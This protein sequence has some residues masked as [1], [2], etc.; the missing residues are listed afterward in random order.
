M[1]NEREIAFAR[2]WEGKEGRQLTVDVVRDA[3][4]AGWSDRPSRVAP[5]P[6]EYSTGAENEHKENSTFVPVQKTGTVL[7]P[8]PGHRAGAE[9]VRLTYTNWRGEIAKRT[10]APKYVWFGSTDWHPHPQWLLKAFDLEKGEDRDFALKDFGEAK[11]AATETANHLRHALKSCIMIMQMAT[12][13][14]G[15]DEF[16]RAYLTEGIHVAENALTPS[17]QP[18]EAVPSTLPVNPTQEGKDNA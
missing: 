13:N 5:E 16:M 7:H 1:A 17:P 11:F 3:Y 14:C 8:A 6:S 2:Y 15:G 10:I 12:R 4:L 9:P 18:T